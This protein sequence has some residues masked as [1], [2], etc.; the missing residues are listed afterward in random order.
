MQLDERDVTRTRASVMHGLFGRP[1]Q[2]VRLGRYELVGTLGT[3]A[4]G[5]VYGAVDPSL[6]RPVAIKVLSE[7]GRRDALVRE[8]RALAR[9]NHPNVVEV[10]EVG[11]DGDD[12]F[13]AME[14]V[15]GPDLRR[16][17]AERTPPPETILAAFQAAAHGLAAAHA[18]GVI[19]RDFKPDNV[20]VAADGRV[21]VADFGLAMS[22]EATGDTTRRSGSGT[23]GTGRG[24]GTPRYMAPELLA[25]GAASV[26]S[27][28]F[29]FCVA[30]VEALTGTMV[31][32]PDEVPRR[33]QPRHVRLALQRGLSPEPGA[34]FADLEV[35]AE[36]LESPRRTAVWGAGLGVVAA[37]MLV[38]T[39]PGAAP[40]CEDAPLPSAQLEPTLQRFERA[41]QQR[42]EI[43]DAGQVRVRV[44]VRDRVAEL[45][46]EHADA[47]QAFEASGHARI[48]DERR[49]CV[50]SLTRGLES[51]LA[52]FV[53]DA[54]SGHFLAQA[55]DGLPNVATCEGTVAI[56]P[57]LAADVERGRTLLLAGRDDG[58]DLLLDV[59]QRASAMHEDR[60]V[61]MADLAVGRTEVEAGEDGTDRLQTAYFRARKVGDDATALAA[62]LALS[63]AASRVGRDRRT[64]EV[65]VEL[66]ASLQARTH[67]LSDGAR[68]A[69]FRARLD[70]DSRNLESALAHTD[71]DLSEHV[72]AVVRANLLSM[73]G[74]ILGQQGRLEDA[75]AAFD[76]SRALL[77]GDYGPEHALVLTAEADL[78]ALA[79]RQGRFEDG[80]DHM[81]RALA[82][83]RALHGDDDLRVATT[84]NAIGAIEGKLGHYDRARDAL[85]TADPVLRARL[86]DEHPRVATNLLNL[87]EVTAREGDIDT[88]IALR[89]Q[90]LS[91]RHAAFGEESAMVAMTYNALG[92][93]YVTGDRAA[94]A[95]DAH[96]RV[97]KIG[98]STTLPPSVIADAHIGL[99][100]AIDDDDRR[101]AIGHLETARTIVGRTLGETHPDY[102]D[103]STNLGI[104]ELREGNA[105]AALDSATAA[106]GAA[107]AHRERGGV[108]VGPSRRCRRLGTPGARACGR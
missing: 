36:A 9:L 82:G 94:D 44:R 104:L 65:W 10:F 38:A 103:V 70:F 106:C 34:R 49:T 22:G 52:A 16:W 7:R 68:V 98:D 100:R 89:L 43:G 57:E 59:R 88:A 92:Q 33:L 99:A 29:A 20:L 41:L 80:L 108:G 86:G 72:P 84:L 15:D 101:T 107:D 3:G 5:R 74:R 13:V 6:R 105:Q 61:A 73:R 97:L 30:A 58:R 69:L 1:P 35:L 28:Q 87:S 90:C 54:L 83:R 53:D 60:V 40:G 47:C 2:R 19:H 18:Q 96:E 23:S 32:T 25:G 42:E 91:I 66:A 64:A 26:A 93:L 45:D 79:F 55:L 17:L 50:G 71:A 67:D 77:A 4:M 62:A 39:R 78:G 76:R 63:D 46:A 37:V 81:R 85:E 95:R 48:F 56:E 12:V 75:Q 51:T 102:A 31:R 21:K 11:V 27:D 14:H 8:A 24:A